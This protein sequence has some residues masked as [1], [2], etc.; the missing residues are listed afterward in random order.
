MGCQYSRNSHANHLSREDL[1]T[2]S[3]IEHECNENESS[4][5]Q[6]YKSGRTT[7]EFKE[8]VHTKV[9][10]GSAVIKAPI[11]ILF[12]FL[13]NQTEFNS[14]ASTIDKQVLSPELERILKRNVQSV[15]DAESINISLLNWLIQMPSPILPRRFLVKESCSYCSDGTQFLFYRGLGNDKQKTRQESKLKRDTMILSSHINV[16]QPLEFWKESLVEGYMLRPLPSNYTEIYFVSSIDPDI[17]VDEYEH[18]AEEHST[19]GMQ[20]VESVIGLGRI[21]IKVESVRRYFEDPKSIWIEQVFR[22]S[23]VHQPGEMGFFPTYDSRIANF[24]VG[25]HVRGKNEG[26]MATG[27]VE[28]F[29]M[30]GTAIIRF[31]NGE[32]SEYNVKEM[33]NNLQVLAPIG[34][35]VRHKIRGLGTLRQYDLEGRIHVKFDNGE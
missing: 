10:R 17:S 3:W 31:D 18:L 34:T 9:W 11:D 5:W 8:S 22:M 2:R 19:A 30:R 7:I 20:L 33:K 13:R 35:R 1:E 27:M 32:T 6:N 29:S 28:S 15:A 26:E 4:A 24:Q 25:S 23:S 21:L 14:L 16:E 12:W